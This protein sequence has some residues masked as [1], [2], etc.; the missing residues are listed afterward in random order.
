M[1]IISR[2][3]IF[4]FLLGQFFFTV[5]GVESY[6]FFHFGMYSAQLSSTMQIELHR[7]Y[8]QNKDI[9]AELNPIARYQLKYC[10]TEINASQFKKWLRFYLP[11]KINDETKINIKIFQ[12]RKDQTIE[13][14]KTL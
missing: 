9:T 3:F 8:Y 5:K 1:S 13:L 14:K 6:P 7:V 11:Q 4:L 12:K 2:L 10:R